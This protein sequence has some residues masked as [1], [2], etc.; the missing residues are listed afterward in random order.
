MSDF[1]PK[2]PYIYQPYGYQDREHWASNRIY[3]IG[4]IN[5]L[6]T[7]KGLTREEAERVLAAL[8]DQ[9]RA[10]E[11]DPL[12]SAMGDKAELKIDFCD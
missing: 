1:E 3:A 4:A 5:P 8:T 10:G 6:A 12:V 9:G 7:I 11:V 2:A